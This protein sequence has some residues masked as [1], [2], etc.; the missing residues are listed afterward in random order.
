MQGLRACLLATAALAAFSAAGGAEGA[1]DVDC[2]KIAMRLDAP[3]FKLACKDLSDSTMLSGG[4]KT[5]QLV[6]V[7]NDKRKILIVLDMRALGTIYIARSSLE[8]DV[9]DVFSSEEIEGWKAGDEALGY[10]LAQ[11]TSAS[12]GADCIAFRRLITRRGPGYGREVIGIGCS[13]TSHDDI[14][15]TLKQ[16]QA[17]GG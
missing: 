17:P 11:Y 7:S 3:D 15:S 16:L 2:G 12:D 6:A 5:E 4:T 13:I 9:K 14:L 10:E 8:K 1:D